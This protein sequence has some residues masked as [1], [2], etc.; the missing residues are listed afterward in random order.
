MKSNRVTHNFQLDSDELF[1]WPILV[2][3]KIVDN[4]CNAPATHEICA[5]KG[6]EIKKHLK[7]R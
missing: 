5:K 2:E 3:S 4:S 7:A 1:K 6:G